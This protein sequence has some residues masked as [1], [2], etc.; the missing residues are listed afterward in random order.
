MAEEDEEPQQYQYKVILL[1]DGSVGKTSIAQRF[2]N[3]YFATSYKQTI[4]IDFFIKR[5]TL[6]GTCEC[7]PL[8]GDRPEGGG[9]VVGLCWCAARVRARCSCCCCDG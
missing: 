1:G 2:A 4:G 9:V 7:S 3:D 5:L 6:P 8:R